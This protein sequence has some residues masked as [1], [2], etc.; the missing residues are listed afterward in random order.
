ML[1]LISPRRMARNCCR[2]SVF[3][4]LGVAAALLS[5]Q[6]SRLDERLARSSCI[7]RLVKVRSDAFCPY[8]LIY[9]HV[10]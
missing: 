7:C 8:M 6:S 10:S 5:N 4:N 1:R 3:L 9:I 2:V